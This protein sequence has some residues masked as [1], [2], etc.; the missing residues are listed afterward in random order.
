[1]YDATYAAVVRARRGE[2]ATL[3][4][5]LVRAGLGKRPSELLAVLGS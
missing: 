2:L 5:E 4:R 3:D 1:V